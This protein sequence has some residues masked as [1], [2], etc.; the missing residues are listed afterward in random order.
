MMQTLT[1]FRRHGNGELLAVLKPEINREMRE[2]CTKDFHTY[3][4]LYQPRQ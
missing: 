1:R 4:Y 2:A 3:N